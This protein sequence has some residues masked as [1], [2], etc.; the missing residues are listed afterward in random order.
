MAIMLCPN[1]QSEVSNEASTCPK[2]GH[3]FKKTAQSMGGC[4]LFMLIVGAVIV[5]VIILAA[6][7]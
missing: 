3:P 5:A 6:G 1:C 4:G 7:L 2:C